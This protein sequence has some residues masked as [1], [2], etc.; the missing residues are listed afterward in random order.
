MSM[1]EPILPFDPLAII[2]LRHNSFEPES[3]IAE[4]IDNSIEANAKN[5]KILIRM[6][7]PPGKQI[8][9]PF[10]MAMGDDGIGM[11]KEDL[12]FCLKMGFS[13]R[14][15]SRAGL[16]RFGVGLTQGSINVCQYTEIYSREKQGN[17]HYV[18]LDIRDIEG[19]D[20]KIKPP[21]QKELPNEYKHLVGDQG[22]LVVWSH[23]DRIKPRHYFTE[24]RVSHFLG[25]TFRKFI[26]TQIIENKAIV[27]NKNKV[28]LFI[29]DGNTEKEITAFDPLYVIPNPLRISDKT[30]EVDEEK[31][32]EYEIGDTDL[33]PGE[34]KRAKI[35]IRTSITPQEWR[36]K[37]GQG[38]SDE[39]KLRY[40]PDNYGFSILRNGREI[41]YETIRNWGAGKQDVDRFW[42]CEID[43]DPILDSRFNI[44]N[45]KVGVSLDKELREE[46]QKTINPAVSTFRKKIR[47]VWKQERQTVLSESGAF[48]HQEA[49]KEVDPIVKPKVGSS[50]T[51]QE[52][53]EKTK[54]IIQD[55]QIDDEDARTFLKKVTD[56]NGPK[57]IAID[58]KQAH[59]DG[60]FIDFE[61]K[62]NKKLLLLNPNHEFWKK[63]YGRFKKIGDLT[64]EEEINSGEILSTTA[65]IKKDIEF[66]LMAFTE[67]YYNLN[68]DTKRD[69]DVGE[70]LQDLLENWSFTLNRIYRNLLN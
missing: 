61:P 4:V 14:Y 23:I 6:R 59:K 45:I 26:G 70:T 12:F 65:A 56:P 50:N 51:P 40:I 25:Q 62:L 47:S 5:I 54:E 31:I 49:E 37:E 52:E 29:S 30:T 1:L 55:R 10:T 38:G 3:A 16:G 48:D 36:E 22:T 44:H 7:V 66:L 20:F 8:E 27:E 13:S 39:N 43:F 35:R 28:N 9:I 19:N 57:I 42:S 2:S 63:L 67:S 34:T 18:K 41:F 21:V 32:E 24:E 68:P 15:N 64:K 53:E 69:Q 33:P 11:N 46:L 60:Q 17:W 58:D